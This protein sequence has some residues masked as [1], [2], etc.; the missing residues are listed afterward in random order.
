MNKTSSNVKTI[1]KSINEYALTV[2]NYYID[3]ILLEFVEY[4]KIEDEVRKMLIS[5]KYI[6]I[7]Q[8]MKNCIFLEIS[9]E[10]GLAI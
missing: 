6:F 1:L 9:S 2:L 10:G 3:I 8:I 4:L 7:P 5:V